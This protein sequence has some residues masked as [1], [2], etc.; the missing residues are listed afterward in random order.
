MYDAFHSLKI[1]FVVSSSVDPDGMPNRHLGVTTCSI[2][3]VE[4]FFLCDQHY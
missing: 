1:V 3:N 2:Q 4:Q